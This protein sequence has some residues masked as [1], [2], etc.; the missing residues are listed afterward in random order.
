M[1]AFAVCLLLLGSKGIMGLHTGLSGDFDMLL[2]ASLTAAVYYW[3]GYVDFGK[4][5]SLY[6]AALCTGLAF[7]CKGT[8]GFIFLPGMALYGWLRKDTMPS[9]PVKPIL[10]AIGLYVMIV[11]S[12]ILLLTL[13]GKT[14]PDSHY[15]SGG[16]LE[17][18]F[19]HDTFRR[20]GSTS[21]DPGKY[22]QDY[23]YFISALDVRL[24]LWNY[25]LY[26]MVAL[27]IYKLYTHRK[28]WLSYLRR[29][30]N[31]LMVLSILLV[32]PLAVLLTI[33]TNKHDWYLAPA[34]CF[35]AYIIIKL[36]AIAGAKFRA[37]YYLC[38]ALL[39]FTLIRHVH[40]MQTLPD[41]LHTAFSNTQ[42]P[43]NRQKPLL[44]FRFPTQHILLYTKWLR[45]NVVKQEDNAALLLTN[46]PHHTLI[47]RATDVNDLPETLRAQP[48]KIVDEYAIVN[49][50]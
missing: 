50:P 44:L 17:T 45:S 43:F 27:G 25:L 32:L 36:V 24:N 2:T 7:Y 11:A 29:E 40:Y 6:L 5:R 15:N 21:F 9:R 30:D 22:K 18:M 39:V 49:I 28:Q 38:A 41:D 48:I 31:R 12:W 26:L 14:G 13:Y 19:L 10:L 46:Y 37:A 3:V 47:F 33:G 20:F 34:C 35:L 1:F 4:K 8:A 16:T 23:A 42:A